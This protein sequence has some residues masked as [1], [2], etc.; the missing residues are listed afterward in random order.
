[1]KLHRY[2]I[3]FD[4]WASPI[5]INAYKLENAIN[6][7]HKLFPVCN[8]GCGESTTIKEVRCLR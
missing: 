7:A 8:C 5:F 2:L 6:R 4:N 1:M 3:M